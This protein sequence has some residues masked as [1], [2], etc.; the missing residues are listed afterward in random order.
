LALAVT[1]PSSQA[2]ISVDPTLQYQ[3]W[4]GWGTSLCWWAHVIGGYPDAV[5]E[6]VMQKTF[7][8]LG[9]NIVRYNIGG[10]ENPEHKHLQPRALVPGYL[11][12][13]GS[14]DWTA[15]ANQRWV[16]QRAKKLGVNRFEAFSNSPPYFMT[17]NGCASGAKDGGSNLD[18]AKMD[19]FADYLVTVVKHFKDN[20]GITFETLTPLNE[21]GADWWKEGGRQEGCHV[22]PGDE[23]SKLLLATARELEKVKSPT[24][25]SGAEE[26]LID[27]S[28]TA[29][30]KMWPEA[31]A[32]LARF[33][34]HT[35]GGSKRRELQERMD[36]FGK[37]FWM[38]EYG[39][40]DPS[41]LT[42]SLQILKDLKQMRPSAWCYWQVV[43]QTGSNWG[44]WDMDLNGGGHTAVT[45]PKLYVMANYSRFIRPGA[46][47][48]EVGDDHTLAA[49]KG[50]DLILVVTR[51]GEGGKTTF[52]LSKFKSVGKDA[53]VYVTAPGKNLAE[54]PRIKIEGKTLQAE[55]EADSV[56]TFVVKGC[57]T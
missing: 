51:K 6:E 10:T 47:F 22:S 54:M 17:L 50:N 20:W 1:I 43:D 16:L 32:K 38:S 41:G 46:R 15:D 34:T 7:K 26:S 44:F 24:K 39:D 31:K 9:F 56:T 27:Q 21:P 23:Q 33:N 55:V 52:D 11:K 3:K 13:D 48:I 45:H 30:D 42:M 57:R 5:R 14:Y 53:Q 12:P 25:L 28:V 29:Y 2:S 40:R 36:M 4:D 19:A 37:P 18:P 8:Y 35:Y 49:M